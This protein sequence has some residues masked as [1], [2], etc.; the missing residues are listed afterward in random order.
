[1]PGRLLG[2]GATCRVELVHVPLP[3]GGP[4]L[5]AARK[6]MPRSRDPHMRAKE[7]AVFARE[8]LGLRAGLGCPFVVRL[9]GTSMH[10]DRQELLMELAE[11]NTIEHELVG[12]RGEHDTS[13]Q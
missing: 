4:P 7:D 12:G 10:P 1:M 6:T 8:V 9:L 2:T 13:Y 11:G 5:M 3:E